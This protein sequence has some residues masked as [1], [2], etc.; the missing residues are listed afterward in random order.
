MLQQRIESCRDGNTGDQHPGR[1]G[2]E[3]VAKTY[4]EERGSKTGCVRTCGG[5]R[6]GSE[7]DQSQS[8]VA[9]H[10]ITAV[11][12]AHVEPC[13]QA[14]VPRESQQ[15]AACGPE[16]EE[17]GDDGQEVSQQTEYQSVGKLPA[18]HPLAPP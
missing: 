12:G 15:Y 3:C 17:Q 9:F 14:L 7:E 10:Y 11:H 6:D 5:E 8:A 1:N 2:D 18:H 16:K 4:V 13:V